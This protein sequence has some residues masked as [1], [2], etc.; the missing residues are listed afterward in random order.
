MASPPIR[1]FSVGHFGGGGDV[2]KGGT[3]ALF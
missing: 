2:F 1:A 3:M